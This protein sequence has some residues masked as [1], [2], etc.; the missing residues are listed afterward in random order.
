MEGERE[1]ERR[2]KSLEGA[3]V[4]RVTFVFKE[5]PNK[6]LQQCKTKVR[7]LFVGFSRGGRGGFFSEH[8]KEQRN[9]E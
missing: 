2:E 4:F 7:Y 1:R 5:H 3:Y 6:N 9:S 8:E